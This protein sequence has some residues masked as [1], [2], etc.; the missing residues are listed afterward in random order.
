MFWVNICG[1]LYHIQEHSSRNTSCFMRAQQFGNLCFWVYLIHSGFLWFLFSHSSTCGMFCAQSVQPFSNLWHN[2]QCGVSQGT[3]SLC[4]SRPA[5]YWSPITPSPSCKVCV[6]VWSVE[7][8][9]SSSGSAARWAHN[10]RTLT[11]RC[12]L[13]C[14]P[15]RSKLKL[16]L[17]GWRVKDEGGI[18]QGKEKLEKKEGK[19]E[20][21]AFNVELLAACN[22]LQERGRR[23]QG[24]GNTQQGGEQQKSR[25][26]SLW[27]THTFMQTQTWTLLDVHTHALDA[28]EGGRGEFREGG[29]QRRSSGNWRER[30]EPEECVQEKTQPALLSVLWRSG[31]HFSSLERG[32]TMT[33]RVWE[34]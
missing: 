33:G 19:R 31:V 1:T 15:L 8:C 5:A 14:K 16:W 17:L 25:G 30:K 13:P 21:E 23:S 27:H 11:K 34:T 7:L 4:L 9:A 28:G 2:E 26:H 32:F 3:R 29:R 10:R 6:C 20:K 24:E 12:R 22:L 18:K